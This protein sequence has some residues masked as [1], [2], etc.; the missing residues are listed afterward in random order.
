MWKTPRVD[1]GSEGRSQTATLKGKKKLKIISIR[2]IH[3]AE[4][5]KGVQIICSLDYD[6]W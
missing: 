6:D 3:R 4:G 1:V 5:E 2:I